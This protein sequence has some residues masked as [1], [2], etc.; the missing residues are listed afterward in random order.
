MVVCPKSV[1]ASWERDIEK[2]SPKQQS[3]LKKVVV[4]NY[5]KVW[6]DKSFDRIWDCIVLD[7]AHSIKNRTSRR[8]EFLLKLSMN[9][10][11]RYLLTG[12][13]IGNGQLENIWS[14]ITFLKPYKSGRSICSEV[15]RDNGCG[16]GTFYDWCD[17]YAFLDQYHK[18]YRYRNINEIQTII[19]RYSFRVTKQQCMD[20]PE[21]LDDEIIL[22]DMPTKIKKLYNDIARKSA[23]LEHDFV[24]DNPLVRLTKLRQICSGWFDNDEERVILDN[25]KI[26]TLEDMIESMDGKLVIF[27]EYKQSIRDIA[28]LLTSMKIKFVYLN[29][30]QKDKGIWREFQTD[31]SIRVIICQYAS[32]CQ[33]IDLFAS[34]TMI[35]YEPTLRSNVLEQARDRIHRHGQ[36][37]PCSYF[38]LLTRGSVELNIYRALKGYTDFSEKL[39]TKYLQEYQRSKR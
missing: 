33:G 14:L 23:S 21:K 7:E 30:E 8:S 35:F 37:H 26:K 19:N 13:P 28:A 3:L 31:E 20:L 32:A 1:I 5:D 12:T 10:K 39:F 2:F 15:F 4:I 16:R 24:A 9:A 22:V 36:H 18:P 34:S 29:G 38:F 11:Y 6:R 25:E 17:S 27:V